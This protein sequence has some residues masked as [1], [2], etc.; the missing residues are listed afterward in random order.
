MKK[1]NEHIPK[2]LTIGK[3]RTALKKRYTGSGKAYN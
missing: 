2:E 1:I 3:G